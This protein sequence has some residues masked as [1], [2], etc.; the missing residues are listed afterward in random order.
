MADLPTWVTLSL[1]EAW[2]PDQLAERAIALGIRADLTRDGIQLPSGFLARIEPA[3]ISPRLL[4]TSLAEAAIE[5]GA[6]SLHISGGTNELAQ[7]TH[8]QPP[9]L[10]REVSASVDR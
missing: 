8:K 2:S 10:R 9:D 3:V 4:D 6:A 7:Q 5:L 1:R